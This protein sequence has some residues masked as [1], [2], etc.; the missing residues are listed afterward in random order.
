[1]SAPREDTKRADAPLIEA[2]RLFERV[3][4]KGHRYLVG[5]MGGV[6]VLVFEKKE[7]DGGNHSHVLMIGAAPAPGG[8]HARQGASARGA[9]SAG[10]DAT[11]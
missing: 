11:E 3:S 6:R 5:R 8:E 2:A 4:S 9:G 7:G 1:M 10:R